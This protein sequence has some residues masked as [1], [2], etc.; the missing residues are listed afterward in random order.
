MPG[1]QEVDNTVHGKGLSAN[2]F[3][4]N[5]FFVTTYLRRYINSVIYYTK[6]RK[7][8]TDAYS[9]HRK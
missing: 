9:S 3:S 1:L 2:I 6:G 8:D 7:W 4:V 5:L